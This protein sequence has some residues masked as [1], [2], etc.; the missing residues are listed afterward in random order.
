[1]S[2]NNAIWGLVMM[3]V[4]LV[5]TVGL[6]ALHTY[7]GWLSVVVAGAGVIAVIRYIDDKRSRPS[8][9]SEE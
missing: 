3:P 9:T 8:P 6:L 4:M 7:F 5:V 1:M 2:A